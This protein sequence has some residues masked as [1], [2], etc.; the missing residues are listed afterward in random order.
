MNVAANPLFTSSY[1]SI[2]GGLVIVSADDPNMHSSQNEQDNRNYATAAKVPMLEPSDSQE[3]KDFTGFA[4]LLSEE[5]DTLVLL[6]TTTRISHSKGM[7]SPERKQYEIPG[8]Q[9]ASSN[10]IHRGFQ[11]NLKK[12]VMIPAYARLRHPV[13]EDRIATLRKHANRMPI[14]QVEMKNCAVGAITSGI[15]YHYVREVFPDVSILKLGMVYP[16]QER[17][18]RDFVE[19]VKKVVVVEELDPFFENQIKAM[20]IAIEEKRYFP[21]TGEFDPSL[22]QK[23]FPFQK[24]RVAADRIPSPDITVP[25]RPPQLCPGCPHHT[26]FHVLQKLKAVV[27]GDIG[28]YTLGVLPPYQAMDTC[29]EMG[30]SIGLAQG[31]KLAEPPDS[32]R[33]IVAV[34]GDSTFTI[35][36]YPV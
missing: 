36:V 5:Y 6:R 12:Y 32:E 24:Q 13:V 14:N 35:P 34:I 27:S 7:V 15:C 10:S 30:G 17:M 11:R 4:F 18:I 19:A 31:M 28:C 3:A 16:L 29:I 26:V 20:G 2:H 23:H 9:N 21:Q 22:I 8:S 25:P 1:T 33:P